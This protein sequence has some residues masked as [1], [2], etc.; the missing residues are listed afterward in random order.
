[1]VDLDFRADEALNEELP[2]EVTVQLLQ[3]AQEALSNIARHSGATRASVAVEAGH[4][5]GDQVVLEIA[6]NGTGFDPGEDRSEDHHGLLN[7]RAR[8][9]SIGGRLEIMS[10]PGDGHAYH[11]PGPASRH[12][13]PGLTR[14]GGWSCPIPAPARERSPDRSGS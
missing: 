1:M 10:E 11:R 5:D 3:I 2:T 4:D 9:G 7:M 6:D 8:V 12:R 14:E 13:R